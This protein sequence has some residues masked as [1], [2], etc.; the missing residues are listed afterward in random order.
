[1]QKGVVQKRVVLKKVALT[2]FSTSS[3]IAVVIANM[4]G[5]GVF[6]SLGYQLVD[7]KSVFVLLLLWFV[8]GITALCGALTY[9]ELSSALPRSGGEYNFLGQ[10]YHPSFG[11]VSGWV[12]AT[13]GFGAPTALAA[14]TFAAYLSAALGDSYEINR[15]LAAVGLVI[16]VTITHGISHQA[17][18]GF[19]RW[20]TFLKIALI[21][22]FSLVVVIYAE[23]RTQIS[24]MPAEG[25]LDLIFGS[26][27]AI[28]LI[29]VSYAYTGWNAA[30]YITSEVE[31]PQKNM[32]RILFLS[33][34][35]VMV[36]YLLLNFVFLYAAPMSLLEGNIEIGVIVAESTFGSTGA[37]VM[38]FVL[39]MMLISTVSAMILAGPRVLQVIGEDFKAFGFLSK[40]NRNGI[41]AR[42]IYF[43]STLTIIFIL[44][45]SFESVLVFAGFIMGINSLLTVMGVFVLRC[46]SPQEANPSNRYRTWG[47]PFTPLVFIAI[48]LWTL[49]FILI[50]RPIEAGV[51]LAIVAAGL[52]VYFLSE[53]FQNQE[54][55]SGASEYE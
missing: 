49:T 21:V 23:P 2:K 42:A 48:T 19:Q 46:N 12:S 4:V 24:I 53:R 9:A 6:T 50:N 40:K 25:D 33:T 26:A 8:G 5:T 31:D 45:A 41:P 28:S 13:V 15:E 22:L 47:Y 38:G 35:V 43:Q 14:M 44:T 55:R 7:I 1:V 51:G 36:L 20:F 16:V 27:F 18:S 52:I 39:S 37:L 32:P 29:Y 30:T 11:F 17:S 54:Q 3:A 34:L 10:I